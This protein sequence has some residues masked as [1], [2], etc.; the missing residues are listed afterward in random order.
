DRALA[1]TGQRVT[2]L[3]PSTPTSFAIVFG[4]IV[5]NSHSAAETVL[6]FKPTSAPSFL[7]DNP[8]AIRSAR[9]RSPNVVGR[10]SRHFK[11]STAILRRYFPRRR[12]TTLQ[13]EHRSSEGLYRPMFV[14]VNIW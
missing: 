8:A 11:Q 10:L 9:R 6:P 7:V 5:R 2:I 4:L 13:D 3:G 14:P 1:G 12:M